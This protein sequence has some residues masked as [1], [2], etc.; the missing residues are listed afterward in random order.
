MFFLVVAFCSCKKSLAPNST[1]SAP[2][3]AATKT[4]SLGV[5]S[6]PPTDAHIGVTGLSTLTHDTKS[7]TIEMQEI[8]AP[9]HTHEDGDVPVHTPYLVVPDNAKI[10]PLPFGIEHTQGF[11]LYQLAGDMEIDAG[12]GSPSWKDS[13]PSTRCWSDPSNMISVPHIAVLD[14]SCSSSTPQNAAKVKV[15]GGL[16]A[17]AYVKSTRLRDFGVKGK[18]PNVKDA[19][20]ARLVDLAY[21]SDRIVIKQGGSPVLTLTRNGSAEL[22]AVFVNASSADL[23]SALGGAV[24]TDA[25]DH[26]FEAFYN[27]CKTAADKRPV[28]RPNTTTCP[29]DTP[30]A[31]TTGT[32]FPPPAT[33]AKT[34]GKS[35]LSPWDV[36]IVGS[37]DCGPD[38]WP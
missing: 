5:V 32:P 30:P 23:H 10:S 16:D 33:L 26:H 1:S 34:T 4:A 7:V 21:K 28:P 2:L 17:K 11:F 19:R 22:F 27:R 31:W 6:G 14:T 20:I 18:S 9:M 38:Q 12:S 25:V 35:L 29:A 8:S 13:A 15:S 36:F 37:V 24:S 3:P